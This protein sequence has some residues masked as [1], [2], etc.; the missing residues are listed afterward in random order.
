MDPIALDEG[1][2]MWSSAK[3]F[4]LAVV[5]AG[6]GF[7]A[8][9]RLPFALY[10]FGVG[11]F[12]VAYA[13]CLL[14]VAWPVAVTEVFLGQHCRKGAI[15]A[16]ASVHERARGVGVTA[17]LFGFAVAVYFSVALSWIVYPFFVGTTQSPMPF[18][19]HGASV[20]TMR[21][22]IFDNALYSSGANYPVFIAVG[23]VW[24]VALAVASRGVRSVTWVV[25]VTVPIPALLLLGLAVFSVASHAGGRL[26]L[27]VLGDLANLSLWAN[28]LGQSLLTAQA[29]AGVLVAGGSA[30]RPIFNSLRIA[31]Y[32]VGFGLLLSCC[33]ALCT[34]SALDALHWQGPTGDA[35]GDDSG[36]VVAMVV[37]PALLLRTAMGNVFAGFFFVCV[38]AL[39]VATV[40]TKVHDATTAIGDLSISHRAAPVAVGCTI[41]GIVFSFPLALRVAYPAV[42]ALDQAV[43][44]VVLPLTVLMECIVVGYMWE[45]RSISEMVDDEDDHVEGCTRV[46]ALLRVAY[47]HSIGKIRALLRE[48]GHHLFAAAAFPFLIKFFVP[49]VAAVFIVGHVFVFLRAS[50]VDA[51]VPICVFCGVSLLPFGVVTA[52][53]CV[54]KP[55]KVVNP[56]ADA[57]N[58]EAVTTV[59]AFTAAAASHHSPESHHVELRAA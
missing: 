56:W 51:V 8:I 38:A 47:H 34:A 2:A 46:G 21:A 1:R 18:A 41:V 36:F 13:L 6:C 52:A 40:A 50:G 9:V 48:Q 57:A 43:V 20:A 58:I 14:L 19:A 23:A 59:D 49:V 7:G 29:G 54:A 24:L 11:S 42:V 45:D 22:Y 31:R 16:F 27:P 4:G 3:A 53:A 15:A 37:Y 17:S 26:L 33:V 35:S 28:A 12:M 25:Y 32:T 30:C 44:G 39:G 55:R 5:G 10:T